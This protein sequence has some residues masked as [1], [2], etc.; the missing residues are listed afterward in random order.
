MQ[1]VALS[2]PNCGSG[3]SR[4]RARCE[5]CGTVTTISSDQSRAISIGVACPKCNATN[6]ENEKHCGQCGAVLLVECPKPG[7]LQENSIWRKHCKK[8]G[9]DIQE[10]WHLEI[11]ERIAEIKEKLPHNRSELKRVAAELENAKGRETITK[12]IISG[13]GVV[14]SLFILASA[15]AGGIVGVLIV[16]AIAWIWAANHKSEEKLML[17]ESANHY[18]TESEELEAELK[19]LNER[20]NELD[21]TKT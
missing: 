10:A 13:V 16:M 6:N 4:E 5:Y 11:D 14:I 9:T 1:V 19:S 20:I 3:L 8:C 12:I 15:G 21:G 17:L 18:L 7:C 2:C